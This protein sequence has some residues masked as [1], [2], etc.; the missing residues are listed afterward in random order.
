MTS[1]LFDPAI[2]GDAQAAV[3]FMTSMLQASTEYA[4]VAQ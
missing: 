2:V 4:I 3:N 1:T